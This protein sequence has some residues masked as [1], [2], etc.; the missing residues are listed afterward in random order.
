MHASKDVY[1]Y[2]TVFVRSTNDKSLVAAAALMVTSG[3]VL[4]LS[5]ILGIFG[6]LKKNRNMLN[7]VSA[8][9]TCVEWYSYVH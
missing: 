9:L 6:A 5:A 8:V 1:A 2:I 4:F 3:V 7:L